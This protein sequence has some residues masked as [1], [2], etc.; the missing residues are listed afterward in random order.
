MIHTSV[1]GNY[2]NTFKYLNKMSKLDF[3][4]ILEKY[5]RRGVE[6]LRYNTPKDTG[7]TAA[8]WSYEIV[9]GK[10][11][12][13]IHWLNNNKTTTG[14][15]IVILLWYGHSTNR[16]AFVQGNDFINPV[17]EELFKELAQDLEKEVSGI[18]V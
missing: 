3:K 16:G 13:T 10:D 6:L 9:Y 14:V 18:G 2:N 15:P 4:R 12:A 7:K 17:I 8:S 11:S 1:K 5:G